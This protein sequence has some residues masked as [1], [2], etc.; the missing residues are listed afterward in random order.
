MLLLNRLSNCLINEDF[1]PTG[2]FTA[3]FLPISLCSRNIIDLWI[4]DRVCGLIFL[5]KIYILPRLRHVRKY[6]LT[7]NM[8]PLENTD[9]DSKYE[10]PGEYKL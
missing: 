7:R 6:T 1:H 8:S 3:P 4:F 5:V 9:F 2:C 10:S